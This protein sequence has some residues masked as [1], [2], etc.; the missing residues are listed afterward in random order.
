MLEQC[1]RIFHFEKVTKIRNKVIQ[2]MTLPSTFQNCHHSDLSNITLLRESQKLSYLFIL[3]DVGDNYWILFFFVPNAHDMSLMSHDSWLM[4]QNSENVVDVFQ[5]SETDLI[6]L[7]MI[8]VWFFML[9]KQ[10]TCFSWNSWFLSFFIK[11]FKKILSKN[12]NELFVKWKFFVQHMCFQR[13]SARFSKIQ[14]FLAARNSR[15]FQDSVGYS[16]SQVV[17]KWSTIWSPSVY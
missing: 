15:K 17:T 13:D 7:K 1:R 5:F 3:A 16:M 10:K 2:I 12:F 8:S 6:H 14:R 4:N 11:N 9:P